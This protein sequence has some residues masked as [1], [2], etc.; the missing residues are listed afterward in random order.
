MRTLI[1]LL[2]VIVSGCATRPEWLGNRAVCTV[3]GDQA[4]V[5]SLWGFVGISS[6]LDDADRK[7]MCKPP[8]P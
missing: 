1:L 6:P 3:A 7:V 5:I 4:H 2:A 8:Q